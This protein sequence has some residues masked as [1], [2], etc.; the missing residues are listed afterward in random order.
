MK[1]VLLLF[2]GLV[3]VSCSKNDDEETFLEKYNG[4]AYYLADLPDL[5]FGEQRVEGDGDY[6]FISDSDS[7][8][9]GVSIKF[10]YGTFC[11]IVEEGRGYMNTQKYGPQ[12][13]QYD[14]R[15]NNDETISIIT[16][17]SSNLVIQIENGDG[18]IE[19]LKF[20]V[21][22]SGM[23]LTVQ[24]GSNFDDDLEVFVDEIIY[25]E[26]DFETFTKVDATFE[27]RCNYEST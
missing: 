11:Y 19:R 26:E 27:E 2:L 18:F 23:I 14:W 15:T 8:L 12:A 16:N 7:F 5:D 25:G 20:T 1:K 10:N 24:S 3:I 22:S 9:K 6:I 17:N 21:D 13:E 4:S